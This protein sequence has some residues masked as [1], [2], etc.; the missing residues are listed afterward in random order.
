[1]NEN[2]N[3]DDNI[4]SLKA[5]FWYTL[6]NL[7]T[8]LL[9]FLS[10]GFFS[11]VMVKS[12]FGEY[13]TFLAWQSIIGFIVTLNL[14][15]SLISA[16]YELKEK[17][18][19]YA[20]SCVILGWI[21][22]L[23]C[24]VAVNLLTRVF[25]GLIKYNIGYINII[26]IYLAFFLVVEMFK[27]KNQI[28]FNHRATM[29]T[30]LCTTFLSTV[31]SMVLVMLMDNKLNARI[32]GGLIPTVAVGMVLFVVLARQGQRVVPAHWKYALPICLPYIPHLLSMTLLNSMDRIMVTDIC[33]SES[34]ADYS[35]AYKCGLII[36]I[37]STAMNNSYSP[38]LG[39][40][41][42]D[43][44]YEQIKSFSKTYVLIFSLFAAGFMLLAPEALL[45]IGGKEYMGAKYALLPVICGVSYQFIYTMF[46][47]IEQV[48]RKTVG[49]AVGSAF[50]ALS[51]YILNMVFIP[52]YGY[53][54]AAFTT[55]AS[56]F[57]LMLFHLILVKIIGYSKVY[58]YKFM[59]IVSASFACFVLVCENLYRLNGIR[60]AAVAVYIVLLI[61]MFMMNR[62][63]IMELL[64][65]LK[66]KA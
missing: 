26:F 18:H 54:A 61:V 14:D 5:G 38:W 59:L 42:S 56:Y 3:K 65:M 16:R 60:Y 51:N 25:P 6:L 8:G 4:R 24:C 52:K 37:L 66:T 43:K 57:L 21:S 2:I 15:S 19:E 20:F 12:D 1:M 9:T 53:I 36:S 58:D 23:V 62:S 45:I 30:V 39:K 47:N 50:A 64:K 55:M 32:Y 49:M 7:A 41:L 22:T 40:Q 10:T 11:R 28:I 46:V 33:G 29:I 63:R 13:E 31:L 17:Y 44:N 27:T 48:K 34:N 35:I